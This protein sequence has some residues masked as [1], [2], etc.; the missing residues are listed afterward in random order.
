MDDWISLNVGGTIFQTTRGTLCKDQNSMLSRMFSPTSWITSKTDANGAY[1]LDRDARYFSPLLN[2]LRH[3]RGELIMDPGLNPEGVLREAEFFQLEGAISQLR[4][5][6][7]AQR[8]AIKEKEKEGKGNLF[9]VVHRAFYLTDRVLSDYLLLEGHV[10]EGLMN[11][12]EG[13]S[14]HD[15]IWVLT[16][17]RLAGTNNT[18]TFSV[19][20][21]MLANNGWHI[22]GSSG[23][24]DAWKDSM[25]WQNPQYQ[26][27]VLCK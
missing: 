24:S 27:Y 21:H 26:S 10:E 14:F 22:C 8:L 12:L 9:V 4:D 5:I 11:Q 7:H 6:V 3:A 25:I 23:S 1:L 13:C 17:S 15:G 16:H 2:Y 20:L 19:L 18:L